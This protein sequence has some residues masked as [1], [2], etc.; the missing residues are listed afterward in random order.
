MDRFPSKTNRTFKPH[1]DRVPQSVARA[2][3]VMA[4]R[5][6]ASGAIWLVGGSC[7]ALLQG[8][9]LQAAPRD[10]DVYADTDEAL[11][12]HAALADFSIDEQSY[13]ETGMYGSLLSHYAIEGVAVELV[14]SLTVKMTDADYE[15]R[16]RSLLA[17]HGDSGLVGDACIRFM[18]LVHELL[19]NVLRNRR[20]RYEPIARTIMESKERH[21]PLLRDMMR[22]NRIGPLYAKRIKELLALPDD[23]EGAADER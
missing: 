21:L 18:P 8:V 15:V 14:G 9:P 16:I 2:L 4:E 17:A 23:W 20:D 10:L 3:A 6:E 5:L 19:F 22:D 11:A 7:G 13:S 1:T 12:I